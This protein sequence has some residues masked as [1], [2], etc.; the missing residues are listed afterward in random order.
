MSAYKLEHGH[1]AAR[2]VCVD[3][4]APVGRVPLP[5]AEVPIEAIAIQIRQLLFRY[6]AVKLAGV[7]AADLPFLLLPGREAWRFSA[8]LKD[9]RT[10]QP[11]QVKWAFIAEEAVE[12][13]GR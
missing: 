6:I 10:I 11:G 8:D 3:K 12:L 13:R 2:F 5:P 1:H 9:N 7:S 4:T